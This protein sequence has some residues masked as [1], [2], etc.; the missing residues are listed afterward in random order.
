MLSLFDSYEQAK[1]FTFFSPQK[2]LR[3]FCCH[4]RI[5]TVS[6]ALDWS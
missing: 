3:L 5:R 6:V 4:K 1:Q 2:M